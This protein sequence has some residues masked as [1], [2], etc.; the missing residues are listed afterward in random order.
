MR[1]DSN[2]LEYYDLIISR[3]ICSQI[4]HH[5]NTKEMTENIH[6]LSQ[7][8]LHIEQERV[9]TFHLHL[10]TTTELSHTKPKFPKPKVTHQHQEPLDPQMPSSPAYSGH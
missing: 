6:S 10:R 4:I 2:P 1:Q 8:F 7:I 3:D 9:D 5:C